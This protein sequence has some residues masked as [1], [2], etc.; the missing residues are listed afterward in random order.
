[1]ISAV[2]Y[3]K[4]RKENFSSECFSVIIEVAGNESGLSGGRE[5]NCAWNARVGE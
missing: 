4:D 2:F 5:Q 3:L 1:M